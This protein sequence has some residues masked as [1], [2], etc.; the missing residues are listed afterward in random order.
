[1]CVDC[2]AEYSGDSDD[3]VIDPI[4]VRSQRKVM[5]STKPAEVHSVLMLKY[6]ILYLG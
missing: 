3:G 6:L 4:A 1:M 5:P 2:V